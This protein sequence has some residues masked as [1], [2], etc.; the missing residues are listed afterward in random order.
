MKKIYIKTTEACQLQCDHCYIGDNRKLKGFFDEDKTIYWLK[1]YMDIFTIKESDVHFSFHGGEPFLCPLD[2]M[3]KVIDAFPNATYDATSN[4]C[5]G[6]SIDKMQ[7]IKNNFIDK[8][9]TKRPF[10]KTSWDHKIRFHSKE[11]AILWINNV[12]TLMLEG[13]DIRVIICL[14]KPLLANFIPKD[15]M[16]FLI[17]LDITDIHFERLTENTTV[18]KSLIPDY[19]K[20]DEWL[21]QFYEVSKGKI[22][23]DIFEELK[24]ACNNTFINCRNRSCMKE[25]ITINANGTIGGCPNSSIGSHYTD[26]N[27]SSCNGCKNNKHQELINTEQTKE[28][29]CYICDLYHICNGDCHQLSWQNGICPSPKKL[30][31]RIKNDMERE[32][33]IIVSNK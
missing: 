4:L 14:T 20:Q 12:K 5:F 11:N 2:K 23:V 13:I 31:R 29:E 17:E 15:L 22:T 1:K 30:I 32:K 6:L 9:G 21:L 27:Q 33:K 26:I 25:V 8:Y 10:I 7:F 3:Q 28:L 24:Y 19:D 16:E 18:D